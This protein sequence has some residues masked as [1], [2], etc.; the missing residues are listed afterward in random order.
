MCYQNNPLVCMCDPIMFDAVNLIDDFVSISIKN[1][2]KIN[3]LVISRMRKKWTK[4]A[5]G[6]DA[7]NYE[8]VSK[9]IMHMPNVD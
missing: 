4:D 7:N 2:K 8:E 3:S 9:T 6:Q 1:D 5:V